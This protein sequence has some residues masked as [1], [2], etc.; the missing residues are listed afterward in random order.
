MRHPTPAIE[1]GI[2]YGRLELGLD[3]SAQAWIDRLAADP[4]L[5]TARRVWTSPAIRC[6]VPAHAMALALAVPVTVDPRLRELDFGHWEGQPW[7]AISRTELDRWAA[8]PLSF[9]PP[10]GESGADLIAR[11]RAF[12]ADLH[13]ENQD[14]VVVSHGGPLKILDALLRGKPVDL[15]AAPPPIG[16]VSFVDCHAA[17]VA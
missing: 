10:G 1:P 4:P 14:C 17:S 3:P 7:D 11:V 8:A 6:H 12:H 5:P 15:L 13:R 2:C 9:A 16:S